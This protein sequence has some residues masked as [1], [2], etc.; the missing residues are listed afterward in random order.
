MIHEYKYIAENVY[1]QLWCHWRRIKWKVTWKMNRKLR[2]LRKVKKLL[3]KLKT[4]IGRLFGTSKGLFLRRGRRMQ[5]DI[6]MS[7]MPPSVWN[8]RSKWPTPFET[9]RLRQI[10]AF[11]VWTVRIAKNVELWWIESQPQAFQRAVD[12][13]RTL[14]LSTPKSGSIKHFFRFK[15]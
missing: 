12:G 14:P 1:S 7:T 9:R 11:N 4:C 13:V 10:F 8:L 6:E 15:K 2:F 5:F 3:I